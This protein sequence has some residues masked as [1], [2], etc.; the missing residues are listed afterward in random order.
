MDT[1]QYAV[2]FGAAGYEDYT[3]H[4]D[5]ERMMRYK[6]RHRNDNI[7]VFDTPGALS[8]WI[9]W[10]KPSLRESIAD[11]KRHFNLK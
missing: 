1:T 5:R 2:H 10:N 3:T 8:W 4:K 6:N 7:N 9:L 11:Y